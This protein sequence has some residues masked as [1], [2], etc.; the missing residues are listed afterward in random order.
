MFR[1]EVKDQSVDGSSPAD[2]VVM[3]D[4]LLYPK[5]DRSICLQARVSSCATESTVERVQS[6]LHTAPRTSLRYLVASGALVV[7]HMSEIFVSV[8]ARPR[9]KPGELRVA[10]LDPFDELVEAIRLILDHNYDLKE[11]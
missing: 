6:K 7:E 9:C 10:A 4:L 8:V 3:L 1:S 11:V 5:L 2:D